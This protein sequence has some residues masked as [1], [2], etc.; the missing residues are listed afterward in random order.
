MTADKVGG[1]TDITISI[2][3]T[4]NRD[5][6]LE[7][8]RSLTQDDDHRSSFEI[9]VLDN[10]SDDDSVAAVKHSFPEVT[11]IEQPYRAGFGANHNRVV[12]ETDSRYIY[13]L[14]ED[15]ISSPGSIDRMIE[16][17][18]RSPRV[19]MLGPRI[20]GGDGRQQPS[21]WRLMS[22]PVCAAW[23]FTIGQVGVVQSKGYRPKA[24][25]AV[26]ACAMILRREPFEEIGMFD[27]RFFIYCEE[28]DTA[29]RLAVRGYEAHYF[30]PVEVIHLGQ[31]STSGSPVRL[32]NE[33]WRSLNMYLSKYHSRTA[34]RI[35]RILLGVGYLGAGI[36]A[37]VVRALPRGL[38]P[39]AARSWSA[40]T[41]FL[42]ATTAFRGPRGEGIREAAEHWNVKHGRSSPLQ[43]R[44][45]G[46]A[47]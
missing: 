40:P 9:V 22:L 6:L 11:V 10:A 14:N 17:L 34:A 1:L 26:S 38:Q 12:R 36:A 41:Y 32:V 7:C 20:V 25:G 31:Q 28:A 2:V 27:E 23:A 42:Q 3:N 39:S 43:I 16:Y 15:T 47:A 30:P 46:D 18:D 4:S 5:L 33:N 8:L 13:V 35:M 37:S 44:P 21:A 19:A 24:V 29:C 45:S